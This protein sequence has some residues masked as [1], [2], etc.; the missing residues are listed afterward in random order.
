MQ[1]QP[2]RK[3]GCDSWNFEKP[4]KLVISMVPIRKVDFHVSAMHDRNFNPNF[5]TDITESAGVH[6][7]ASYMQ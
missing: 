2:K 4:K 7:L 3:L 6:I 5:F 1:M